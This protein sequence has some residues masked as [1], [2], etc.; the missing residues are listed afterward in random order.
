MTDWFQV[1][2]QLSTLAKRQIFFVGGAPRSGTTWLQQIINQ[3]PHA[4]CRGEGLFSKDLFALFD[5][6][7]TKRRVSLEAKNKNVFS[8][9][10]GYPLPS[11]SDGRFLA[12]TA[13]LL[14][15]HQQAAGKDYLAYGEKTP[16]NVFAFPQFKRLFPHSKL[17]AIAR[18]PRDLLTSAWH[19]FRGKDGGLQNEEAKSAFVQSALPSINEG[20]RIILDHRSADPTS[21][22][23]VTYEQLHRASATHV[24]AIFR[25]LGLEATDSIV[26]ACLNATRFEKLAGGRKPGDGVDGA[27]LRKGVVGDWQSTLSPAVNTLILQHLGWAFAKFGW[28]P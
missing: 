10:Q 28:T 2:E 24:A 27:F 6:C 17:V 19:F 12:A 25:F 5:D 20:M 3:H 14:A 15:F 1:N 4:S 22:Y 23:I 21:C 16:E 13:M 8:H 7:M 26:T 9:T 18:D 11:D